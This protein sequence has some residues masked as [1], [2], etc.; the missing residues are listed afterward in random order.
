MAF[1][2][3]VI[4]TSVSLVVRVKIYC[5]LTDQ[6]CLQRPHLESNQRSVDSKRLLRATEA[7]SGVVARSP[8]L[9]EEVSSGTHL[10]PKPSKGHPLQPLKI[11]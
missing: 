8:F 6:V 11:K 1:E 9:S 10:V 2:L 7:H 5:P 3:H 4:K